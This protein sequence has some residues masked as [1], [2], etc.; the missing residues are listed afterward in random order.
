MSFLFLECIVIFSAL[1]L[2][3]MII[4]R[5]F[6]SRFYVERSL[7]LY[8]FSILAWNLF[9]RVGFEERVI[10]AVTVGLFW[11]FKM[12]VIVNILNS[13]S[14][15]MVGTLAVAQDLKMERSRFLDL[16]SA[17]KLLIHRTE[18]LCASGLMEELKPGEFALTAK[19]QRLA[20]LFLSV[21]RFFR[22][23]HIG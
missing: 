19:G 3:H 4:T 5:I 17:Q 21:Q 1:I 10:V 8:F 14:F 18:M 7:K 20:S 13:V 15:R 23:T 11:A 12:V 2:L 22:I 6:G 9:A 16:F